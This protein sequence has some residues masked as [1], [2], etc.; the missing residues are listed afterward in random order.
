VVAS[1]KMSI[2]ASASQVQFEMV[3]SLNTFSFEVSGKVIHANCIACLL[4]T[5][6]AKNV[7]V[8]NHGMAV[9]P[10]G[11]AMSFFAR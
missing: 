7:L 9:H 5:R 11:G 8:K 3:W 10:F 2:I 6:A 4:V 1:L